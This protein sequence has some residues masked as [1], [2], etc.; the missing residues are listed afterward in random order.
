M[1]EIG[2]GGRRALKKKEQE[3]S[4]L[5][6]AALIGKLSGLEE[7]RP[8]RRME[9]GRDR[10][11]GPGGM[12]AF[13]G[14][15]AA[16]KQPSPYLRTSAG[17]TTGGGSREDDMRENHTRREGKIYIKPQDKAAGEAPPDYRESPHQ[18]SA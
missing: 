13:Y 15:L 5:I 18:R 1:S 9:K 8:C 12:P 11:R 2:R 17:T 6:L 14:I 10:V 16:N 7:L 3:D 4:F